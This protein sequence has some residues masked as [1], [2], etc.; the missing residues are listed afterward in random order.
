[1]ICNYGKFNYICGKYVIYYMHNLLRILFLFYIL[2]LSSESYSQLQKKD[3]LYVLAN[4]YHKYLFVNNPSKNDIKSIE[5]KMPAELKVSTDFIVQAVTSKNKLLTKPYLSKPEPAVLQQLYIIRAI[6][7]LTRE[8]DAVDFKS[9]IDSLSGSNLDPYILLDNYYNMLFIGVGNKIQPFDLSKIDLILSD[10]NLINDT[11]KGILV[12]RAIELCSKKI[13]GFMNIAKPANTKK[14]I[15]QI[16]EFPTINGKPYY[17]YKEYNFPDF[18]A[19]LFKDNG[20]QSYKSYFIDKL[21]ETLITHMICLKKE[22][23]TEAQKQDLMDNSVLKD[24]V[25]YQHTKYR[26]VLDSNFKEERKQ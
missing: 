8:S 11:E 26:E 3:A 23:G 15:N 1:M 14:A 25:L 24:K 6:S 12:L 5:E 20:M 10:Y 2:S 19:Q 16:K 9:F 21:F 22:G 13:W 18:Q 7:N 4:F 17:Y